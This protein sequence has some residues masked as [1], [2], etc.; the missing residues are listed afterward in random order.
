MK[1]DHVELVHLQFTYPEGRQFLCAGGRCTA[2]LTS[3]VLV[4]TTTGEV[5]VGSAYSHPGLVDLIVRQQ[6]APFLVGQDP[7]EVEAIW[8][9]LYGLTRWYGRKGAAMS[10][11]GAI[12][13]ALWDLR[14]QALGQP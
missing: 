6:F 7:R 10:A 5:G 8:Q 3:L 12:D 2:R 4:H 11:L 9:R 1:I 14:A 13:T